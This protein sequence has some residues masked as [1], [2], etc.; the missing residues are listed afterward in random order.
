MFIKSLYSDLPL[1]TIILNQVF[2][3]SLKYCLSFFIGLLLPVL[4]IIHLFLHLTDT[5]DFPVQELHF[6][7]WSN[8]QGPFCHGGFILVSA[9]VHNT[10]KQNKETSN[11]PVKGQLLL[12]SI[13]ITLDF[14]SL[15][16]Q[17]SFS[18]E[19]IFKIRSKQHDVSTVKKSGGGWMKVLLHS[20]RVIFLK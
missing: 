4:P 6:Q 1:H 18:K 13:Q 10:N 5:I 11:W 16:S 8:K 7:W 9:G 2:F 3:L 12:S 20:I 15:F 14:T 17:K 19:L